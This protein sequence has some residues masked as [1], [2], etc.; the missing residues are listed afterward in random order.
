M[1]STKP[2]GYFTRVE[3]FQYN[4]LERGCW[5]VGS[6]TY[7]QWQEA[8]DRGSARFGRSGWCF[9]PIAADSRRGSWLKKMMEVDL[10]F[11]ACNCR[12]EPLTLAF[13]NQKQVSAACSWD[14]PVKSAVGRWFH[15][16]KLLFAANLWSEF[17]LLSAEL[18]V[19]AGYLH[20]DRSSWSF[21]LWLIQKICFVCD[22]RWDGI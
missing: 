17:R 22:L 9:Q 18:G 20:F 7:R 5:I 14:S 16:E 12:A 21:D 10:L 6:G 4:E 11:L 19:W 2:S 15:L 13:I 8:S 3:G 1:T